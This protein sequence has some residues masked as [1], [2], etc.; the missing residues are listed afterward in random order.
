MRNR[1]TTAPAPVLKLLALLL[2]A[3]AIVSTFA[4]RPGG[5]QIPERPGAGAFLTGQLLIA[6]PD[7]QDPNFARTVLFMVDHGPEGALGIII[8]RVIG[9]G[10]VEM[11][12]KPGI[13]TRKDA[14]IHA[15]P[16]YIP[17]LESAGI[18]W[19]SGYPENQKKGLPYISGLLILNDPET[20]IPISVMDATWITASPRSRITGRQST[21]GCSQSSMTSAA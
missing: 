16:A 12:P 5:A 18:K 4:A 14:F 11:P 19:V 20:G 2:L 17:S 6:T 7:M 13:H 21:V 8:N 1:Q 10:R 9:E 15:M 3:L